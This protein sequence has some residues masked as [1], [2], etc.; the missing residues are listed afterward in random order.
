MRVSV[1]AAGPLTV[2]ATRAAINPRPTATI[3]A[4]NTTRPFETLAPRIAALFSMT[5]S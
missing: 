5:F 2:L 4:N 3:T 1:V